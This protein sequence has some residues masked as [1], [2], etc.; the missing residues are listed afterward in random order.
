ML[1]LS[2]WAAVIYG[3]V[4]V[5]F[6]G[7]YPLFNLEEKNIPA[8]PRIER[9]FELKPGNYLLKIIHKNYAGE[10]IDVVF[11]GEPIRPFRVEKRRNDQTVRFR[12]SPGQIRES[13]LLGIDYRSGVP[14]KVTI[15][16]QNY[17]HSPL[18]NC[19]F[20]FYRSGATGLPE[21]SLLRS[22]C[23]FAFAAL[24]FAA[25]LFGIEETCRK[26]AIRIVG[27]LYLVLSV[28][29]ISN[30]LPFGQPVVFI[31]AGY[32]LFW[33]VVA[34][35]SV[36]ALCVAR[37]FRN[38]ILHYLRLKAD[39]VAVLIFVSLITPVCLLHV[40]Q[41]RPGMYP[42]EAFDETA[43]T[44]TEIPLV[45]KALLGGHILK[46]N[47]FNNFGTPLL[48]DPISNPFALH[49]WPYLVFKPHIAMTINEVTFSIL[50]FWILF[51]FYKRT[52]L[53]FQASILAAFLSFTAPSFLWFIQHHPHQGVL[54]YF[55]CILLL[56]DLALSERK[57]VYYVLLHLGFI[58]FFLSSG[59]M[60][61]FLGVPFLLVF[62]LIIAGRDIRLFGKSF[63]LPLTSALILAHPHLF[64]FLKIAFLTARSGLSLES[65]NQ[66]SFA[67]LLRGCT[68][69]TNTT[70][71]HPD[72]SINYSL[73]VLIF[74]VM[75]FVTF[76]RLRDNPVFR[77]C[78]ILGVLPALLVVLMLRYRW[79]QSALPVVRSV[80]LT[81]V[82]WFA[83]VFLMMPL[84][85]MYDALRYRRISLGRAKYLIGVAAPLLLLVGLGINWDKSLFDVATH[86]LSPAVILSAYY[87]LSKYKR[88]DES[89]FKLFGLLFLALLVV[90]RVGVFEALV[91]GR[92]SPVEATSYRPVEFVRWM[93]PY[94]RVSTCQPR[95][96]LESGS[97]AD[98]AIARYNI[99]GS[100]GRSIIMHKGFRA[101]LERNKLVSI[102][103]LKLF[104]FFKPH[105]PEQVAGFGIRYLAAL[106]EDSSAVE[107]LGWQKLAEA[108]GQALFENPLRPSPF[109]FLSEGRRRFIYDYRFFYDRIEIDVSS[110]V[111]DDCEVVATFIAWP[112][113][114]AELDGEPAEILHREDRFI[115]VNCANGKKL[116]LEFEPYSSLHI[117]MSGIVSIVFVLG[118][119]F[120]TRAKT[121]AVSRG[122]SIQ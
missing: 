95:Q 10:D 110:A 15:R 82:L 107:G 79:M 104:Y 72:F 43:H 76:S 29:A 22:I 98:Q 55:S 103:W 14:E 3:A 67:E 50:T 90:P 86:I 94:Y 119:C 68:F 8:S 121:G 38:I 58:A 49:T 118:C 88:D 27:V 32:F 109:Y 71:Y 47:V 83:G 25:V 54:F 101:F 78:V 75:G 105:S 61:L 34:A 63:I 51:F 36:V 64:Y 6:P 85:R 33:F 111:G 17:R 23:V 74:A 62:S 108:Q 28:A 39:Q 66:Y 31:S 93:E 52:G 42:V 102:G 84:G 13:N 18:S 57:I 99:L 5:D 112:G 24:F 53:S 77:L 92:Y 37:I 16:L 69:L 115:A 120:L 70:G 20:V 65:V 35:V 89:A 96:V 41:T 46:M 117:V 80:D 97:T 9:A 30:V 7:Q 4:V 116:I 26:G 1:L 21:F 19:V 87:L 56:M 2:F 100:A 48:G 44:Y 73:V 12:I 106:S 113:W 45:Q 11:N 59:V 114:K 122:G 91:G 81:R 60:G 40:T